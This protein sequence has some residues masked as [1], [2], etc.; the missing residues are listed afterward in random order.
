MK[1]K[2]R[3]K[4][5]Y[6]DDDTKQVQVELI[7]R[8]EIYYCNLQGDDI[9]EWHETTVEEFKEK[10]KERPRYLVITN[11]WNGYDCGC[12]G[13]ESRVLEYY[14]SL[15]KVK[16]RIKDMPRE[17]VSNKTYLVDVHKVEEVDY[18]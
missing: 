2:K 18:D 7:D 14:W 3:K 1:I 4:Y 17:R 13:Y 16:E 6:R 5:V 9:Y 12:C 11:Y 10:F 15:D 8:E